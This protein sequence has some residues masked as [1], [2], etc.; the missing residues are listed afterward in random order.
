ML[1]VTAGR[2][3]G[4]WLPPLL[5]GFPLLQRTPGEYVCRHHCVLRAADS[6]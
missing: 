6:R 2:P 4:R 3:A 1:V 5:D